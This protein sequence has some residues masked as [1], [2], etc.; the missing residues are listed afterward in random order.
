M[1][2]ENY[3]A[4]RLIG[5]YSLLEA[6]DSVCLEGFKD[7]KKKKVSKEEGER[8]RNSFIKFAKKHDPEKGAKLEKEP[9]LA[10][11]AVKQE[12]D[13]YK[14]WRKEHA[15]LNEILILFLF[16]LIGVAGQEIVRRKARKK[17][18]W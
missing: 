15:A 3:Y 6:S 7:S 2:Y 12:W 5:M 1:D 16:G 4:E 10:K 11:Q 18:N 17:G 9:S 14:E 8:A 13:V